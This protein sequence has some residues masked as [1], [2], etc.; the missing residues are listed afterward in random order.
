[1]CFF[2]KK[3][4]EPAFDKGGFADRITELA[5]RLPE[6]KKRLLLEVSGEREIDRMKKEAAEWA[7]K[8]EEKL[9]SAARL[10]DITV[11]SSDAR[12]NEH[13]KRTAFRLIEELEEHVR[14]CSLH[15]YLMEEKIYPLAVELYGEIRAYGFS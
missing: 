9:R 6:Q 4:K 8:A 15:F 1:M 12:K 11:L 7:V 5:E 10:L 14:A 2:R 3:A 13:L